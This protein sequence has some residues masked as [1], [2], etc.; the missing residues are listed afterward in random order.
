M[1]EVF[2]VI[3]R[4]WNELGTVPDYKKEFFDCPAQSSLL[5]PRVFDLR[6]SYSDPTTCVVQKVSQGD[7]RG[8]DYREAVRTSNVYIKHQRLSGVKQKTENDCVSGRIN[9]AQELNGNLVGKCKLSLKDEPV[10]K[11]DLDSREE[12][13]PVSKE[14][15]SVIAS[16]GDRCS[17]VDDLLMTVRPRSSH[18]S[19]IDFLCPGSVDAA[20]RFDSTSYESR[21]DSLCSAEAKREVPITT[22][23]NN[24]GGT[25]ISLGLFGRTKVEGL[26]GNGKSGQAVTESDRSNTISTHN[27]SDDNGARKHSDKTDGTV[28]SSVVDRSERS[29]QQSRERKVI[30]ARFAESIAAACGNNLTWSEHS[31]DQEHCHV[32]SHGTND[33]TGSLCSTP[34]TKN[35]GNM[36]APLEIG[37][38][39]GSTRAVRIAI[40]AQSKN[41]TSTMSYSRQSSASET[42]GECSTLESL[43]DSESVMQRRRTPRRHASSARFDLL[44]ANDDMSL[45]RDLRRA[46]KLSKLETTASSKA[47]EV[48]EDINLDVNVSELSKSERVPLKTSLKRFRAESGMEQNGDIVESPIDK[49]KK[50]K[51]S[52]AFEALWRQKSVE[53][54]VVIQDEKVYSLGKFS[55]LKFI[56]SMFSISFFFHIFIHMSSLL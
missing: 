55:C 33:D 24:T 9:P 35:S 47:N 51:R 29:V 10:D 14:D 16:I 25:G 5:V 52:V 39:E 53:E 21:F 50:L 38:V 15:K 8:A 44:I 7:R 17:S 46:I 43:R 34:T 6:Q 18:S 54:P 22:G 2:E 23:V 1:R 26:P 12:D 27:D 56:T 32:Y 19:C 11:S 30:S 45:E 4:F 13:L 41:E 3:Y 49:L 37:S 36:S 48:G 40:P 42:N 28:N 31:G 20:S